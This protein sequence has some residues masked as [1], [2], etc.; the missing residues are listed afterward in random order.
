[1][2]EKEEEEEREKKDG[3]DG[4]KEGREKAGSRQPN[5]GLEAQNRLANDEP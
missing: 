5:T 2:G 1:M 3:D 4:G